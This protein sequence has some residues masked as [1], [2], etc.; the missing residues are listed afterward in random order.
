MFF[1]WPFFGPGL[2]RT[3]ALIFRLRMINIIVSYSYDT[4]TLGPTPNVLPT[5]SLRTFETVHQVPNLFFRQPGAV[6]YL[7]SRDAQL[8]TLKVN[9]RTVRVLRRRF[10]TSGMDQ[11]EP[12][13]YPIRAAL[14]DRVFPYLPVDGAPSGFNHTN[15][16]RRGSSSMT[17]RRWACASL[18]LFWIFCEYFVGAIINSWS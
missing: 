1:C 4:S 7:L 16:L 2:A 3:L 12:R 10:E 17:F 14:E 8:P 13:P 5:Y 15:T 18:A 9:H 11:P 6:A